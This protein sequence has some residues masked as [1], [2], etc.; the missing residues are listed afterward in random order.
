GLAVLGIL[1]LLVYEPR[2][3]EPLLELRFFRSVPF[4]GATVTAV[5]AFC[6]FGSFLFLNS[7]YLQDVRGLSALSAGVCTLPV[8]LLIVLLA[9]ISG[10]IVG[11]KGTRV[12]MLVAG[13]ALI[14]FGFAA[15]H[16]TP[17]TPLLALLGTYLLFG[18]SQGTVNPPITN[19]AVSGMPVSMAG[20]AASVASTSRQVGTTLGVAVSG[21]IVGATVSS[22][23]A[24]FTTASHVVWWL[25]LG[26]GVIIFALGLITTSD[27]A[28]ESARR[29]A[30]LFESVER[31]GGERPRQPVSSP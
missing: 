10:R 1:G 3:R 7:L 6:A 14:L 12:P 26:L 22:G 5:A 16:L 15:T 11:T 30:A 28:L 2:R 4:S 25:V 8:A 20:V 27:R 21:S 19:S 18:F 13:T 17:D 9:P 29:A 23:G 24:S 31:G